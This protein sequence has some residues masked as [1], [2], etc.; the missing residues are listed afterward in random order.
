MKKNLQATSQ[1]C[2]HYEQLYTNK[3]DKFLEMYNFPTLNQEEIKN[4]NRTIT[5][6]ETNKNI[7][8]KKVQ[9][10][11]IG[12]ELTSIQFEKS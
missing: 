6:N 4:M 10:G 3:I 11:L 12:E 1:K 5:S 8:T 7:S 9:D 2:D